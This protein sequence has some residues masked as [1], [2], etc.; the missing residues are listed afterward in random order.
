MA[1][2]TGAAP[3]RQAE[4]GRWSLAVTR[5]AAFGVVGRGSGG[6]FQR[7]NLRAGGVRHYRFVGETR[8]P[9]AGEVGFFHQGHDTVV[10]GFDGRTHFEVQLSHFAGHLDASDFIA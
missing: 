1:S 5:T 6:A 8:D 4:Q 7:P 10:D 3:S 2:A 9:G